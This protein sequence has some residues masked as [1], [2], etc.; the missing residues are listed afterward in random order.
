MRQRPSD[1][2]VENARI[3]FRKT[4]RIRNIKWEEPSLTMSISHAMLWI[5]PILTFL[6]GMSPW[7]YILYIF[8][9]ILTRSEI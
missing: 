3:K 7:S 8:L 1:V 2:K 4:I 6:N 5:L 9:E